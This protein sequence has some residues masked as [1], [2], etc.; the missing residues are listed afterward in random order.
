MFDGQP[1][2]VQEEMWAS[3]GSILTSA[4]ITAMKAYVGAYRLMTN[5]ALYEQAKAQI[6]AR[7]WAEYHGEE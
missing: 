7:L 4:E 3:L 2:Y 1:E 6:G 5:P